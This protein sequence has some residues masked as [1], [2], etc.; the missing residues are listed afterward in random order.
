MYVNLCYS[1]DKTLVSI[2]VAGIIFITDKTIYKCLQ[3]LHLLLIKTK[4]SKIFRELIL[5]G[6]LIYMYSELRE[7]QMPRLSPAMRT[8]LSNFTKSCKLS[9][10]TR[11]C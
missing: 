2:Y 10:A 6:H 9:N 7:T 4:F 8:V 1:G 5:H 11:T 3:I